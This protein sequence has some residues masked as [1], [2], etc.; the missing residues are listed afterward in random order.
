MNIAYTMSN[1]LKVT[2]YG[3]EVLRERREVTLARY[4]EPER[5]KGGRRRVAV[6]EEFTELK[7]AERLLAQLKEVRQKLAR[8]GAGAALY[9]AVR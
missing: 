2:Q 9:C 5:L 3:A 8:K 1:H 6:E 7:P 4:K